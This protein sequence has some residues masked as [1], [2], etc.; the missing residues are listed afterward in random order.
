MF[1]ITLKADDEAI[2]GCFNV[3][4]LTLKLGNHVT[5]IYT[6]TDTDTFKVKI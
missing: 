5:P 2:C 6:D 3:K 4:L 1:G